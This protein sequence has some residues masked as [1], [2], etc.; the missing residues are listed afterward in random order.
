MPRLRNAAL[1]VCLFATC[2][3]TADNPFVGTWKV[4]ADKS[5]LAG[6][7]PLQNVTVKYE[8]DGDSLKAT[9]DGTNAQGQAVNFTYEAWTANL[10]PRPARP[11]LTRLLCSASAHTACA[12]QPRKATR[13]PTQIAGS[14]PRMARC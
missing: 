5:K 11:T 9:V 8:M 3:L 12:R 10:A 13:S 6:A 2:L 4:N 1:F 7:E 14:R